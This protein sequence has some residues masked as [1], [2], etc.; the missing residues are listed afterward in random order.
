LSFY[1]CSIRPYIDFSEQTM[2]DL[3]FTK[4]LIERMRVQVGRQRK[5]M[6][7]LQRAGIS[8]ESAEALLQRMLD[9]IETLCAE[10]DRSRP[11]D[12]SPG[13]GAWRPKLVTQKYFADDPDAPPFIKALAEVRLLA[14][15]EGCA[16]AIDMYAEK[17]FCNRI[18]F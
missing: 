15:R 5:E 16:L 13:Q 6:F 7:Q 17:A 12:R 2:P 18:I 3:D 8:T 9:K 4:I 10:R 1:F 14:T 11:T